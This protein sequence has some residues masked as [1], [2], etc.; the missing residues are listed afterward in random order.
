MVGVV[1]GYEAYARYFYEEGVGAGRAGDWDRAATMFDR[2]ASLDP[3]MSIYQFQ[4]GVAY[5]WLSAMSSAAG[6]STSSGSYLS[7]ALQA[8]ETG[9]KREP[10]CALNVANMAAVHWALGDREP[11][12]TEMQRAVALEPKNSLFW[13]RLGS[14]YE[15]GGKAEEAA[16]AYSKA[17]Q[18]DPSLFEPGGWRLSGFRRQNEQA[19]LGMALRGSGSRAGEVYAGYVLAMAP[20]GGASPAD[21]ERAVALGGLSP[22]T[23]ARL[24]VALSNGGEN[25]QGLVMLSESGAQS[26]G[27]AVVIAAKGEMSALN[28]DWQ[29]AE[30][31]AKLAAFIDDTPE[32]NHLL[33]E[34]WLEEAKNLEA[35]AAL[36]ASLPSWPYEWAESY[37]SLVYGV[38]APGIDVTPQLVGQDRMAVQAGRYSEYAG[39]LRRLGFDKQAQAVDNEV[40]AWAPFAKLL[41]RSG[42]AE[43]ASEGW[44]P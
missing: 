16:V 17:V 2:A 24:A 7:R 34:V 10:D 9:M 15:T 36:R 20:E 43:T 32:A 3:A 6:D 21:I 31:F 5:A 33:G 44:E 11:A 23:R 14:Y 25:E 35:A 40:A 30:R 38:N 22:D 39:L 8:M 37:G 18:L 12:I 41:V 19:I 28:G 27:S 29:R 4:R 1:A 42:S 26:P 13:Y